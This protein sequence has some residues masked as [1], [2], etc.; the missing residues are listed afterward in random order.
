MAFIHVPTSTALLVWH[1][2]H[3]PVR[4]QF[5]ATSLRAFY[6]AGLLAIF[7]PTPAPP[8]P[9]QIEGLSLRPLARCSS[10]TEHEA[11]KNTL[12][13]V[14]LSRLAVLKAKIK[15]KR[16]KRFKIPTVGPS[17]PDTTP[18]NHSLAAEI[19]VLAPPEQ[20]RAG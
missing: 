11:N 15:F 16:T 4:G 18:D 12:L 9:M 13:R 10:R 2:R 8:P 5:H 17:P 3:R 6:G 7:P 20:P 14:D 1:L 19:T